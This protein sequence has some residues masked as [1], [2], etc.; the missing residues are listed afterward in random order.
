MLF[1]LNYDNCAGH[2]F[3]SGKTYSDW[4]Q[5]AR[6]PSLGSVLLPYTFCAAVMP[7]TWLT[8]LVV[9]L[10]YGR[11]ANEQS[12]SP[13]VMKCYTEYF[14]S[15]STQNQHQWHLLNIQRPYCC[16]AMLLCNCGCLLYQRP[17]LANTLRHVCNVCVAGDAH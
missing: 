3:Q 5:V 15:K 9:Y 6:V 11:T 17:Q 4:L 16:V 1:P 2:F 7:G 13:T 8:G 14:P 10:G 12:W